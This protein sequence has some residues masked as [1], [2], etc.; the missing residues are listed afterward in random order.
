MLPILAR[1]F[2]RVQ[3]R[4]LGRRTFAMLKELDASQRWPRAQLEELQLARLRGLLSAAYEHSPYWR[5]V[6]DDRGVQPES[7]ASLADLGRLPLLEKSALRERREEMVWREEGPRLKLV[8]TSGSTNEALQFYTNSNREA[9]INAARI[10]GH[11]WIGVNKGDKEVYYWGSP[12]E[13]HAQDRVKRVRDWLV[14]EPLTNGFEIT[15]QAIP[16]YIEQWKTWRPKC[17]FGYPNSFLLMVHMAAK[18]GI[19]L[20]ALRSRGVRVICTTSEMLGEVNRRIISE[21]FGLPVYDSYGLREAGLVGHEC[22]H[23]TMH[24][25]D[26]QV[27]LETIDPRTLRPTDG[28]GELVV[29]SLISR[30]MPVI[31]YRTGDIVTLTRA[32]CPC[33]LAL[34]RME[35]SGGRVADFVVTNQGKWVAGYFI[36]YICRSMKGVVK[37][38]AV[39]DRPG[40]VRVRLVVDGQFPS[41]GAEQ[42]KAAV[43]ARRASDDRI[44]VEIVEDIAP[45]PSGKYRPVI[46]KLAESLQ[47]SGRFTP[48]P[49]DC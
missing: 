37:F 19:D 26:E 35:I 5:S 3:E 27:I 20:K 34:G 16:R 33:G 25:M 38:Q 45:A 39:Q 44:E 43:R 46:G 12:V 23:Q 2:F 14:N 28:E 15:E 18:A 42:V 13:L 1:T 36:I 30:V 48:A 40:E 29:T 10:R 41:D 32:A 21:A 9:A 7:V 31:R 49:A 4:L 47:A 17:L 22:R 11:R 24:T 8:R 6:M